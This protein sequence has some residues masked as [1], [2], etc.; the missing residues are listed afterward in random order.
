MASAFKCAIF[1][2]DG[3]I[4]ETARL[5]SVAWKAMFD[6]FLRGWYAARGETFR[7][8]T[9]D[10]Y[11]QYVDGKPR[12]Q[13]VK[14][15]LDSRGVVLP[16][17]DPEDAVEKQT[18]CGLGNRKNV[19]FQ[20]IIEA[21]G[22][23]V[24]QSSVDFVRELKRRGIRVGVASSS[25]NTVLVLKKAN[26]EDLFETRV[27]GLVSAELGLRGKPDPDIFVVA[28]KNLGFQPP[29]CLMVEDAISGVTAGFRGKFGLVLGI[30]RHIPPDELTR[31]GADIVIKDLGEISVDQVF[32][33]FA[34]GRNVKA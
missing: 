11:I 3:V 28:A 2:L 20:S 27:C 14:S 17:G 26:L 34:S 16:T 9:E 5:H 33:W 22:A 1:D 29:E 7:E 18:C 21:H 10:D 23:D 8:F 6:E 19:N 24:F 15:F 13:G 12:Y 4:T 25:K 30:A 32:E 31:C